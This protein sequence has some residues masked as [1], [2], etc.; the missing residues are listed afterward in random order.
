MGHEALV[1]AEVA[2]ETF[3]GARQRLIGRVHPGSKVG[4]VIDA[5]EMHA[6]PALRAAMAGLATDT[7]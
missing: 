6:K 4:L 7:V 5:S 3:R 2:G 1:V